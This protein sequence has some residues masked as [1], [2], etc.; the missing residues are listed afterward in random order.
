LLSVLIGQNPGSVAR[1]KT[2]DDLL[3]AM[4]LPGNLPASLIDQR[5]DIIQ[6]EQS[7]RAAN[8]RI[9]VAR[10]AY[11]PSLSLTGIF[12][13][14]N[15]DL[16]DWLHSP[17]K[18]WQYGPG[19]DL[20]IFNAGRV[21]NEVRVA[22]ADTEA[23]LAGYRNTVQ[24]ALRE[25]ENALI[26]YQKTREQL[27]SQ[28]KQVSALQKYLG[29][30]QQ[31]Y[32]EGQS[33]YLEVLDA[34]RNLLSSQLSLAQTEGNQLDQFIAVFRSLGGGWVDEADKLTEEPKRETSLVF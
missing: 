19:I 14:V 13:F 22:E 6:A 17:S 5:P 29:L 18:Q 20:P 30:S 33:S 15:S 23:A 8:A 31:R 24:N 27:E 25:V 3:P 2:I 11:F 32:D 4:A 12:G 26:G 1:G 21:G 28:A 10:A 34:Q 9:G 16:S 7:L